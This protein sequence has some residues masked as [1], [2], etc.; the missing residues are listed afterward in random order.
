LLENSNLRIGSANAG[1]FLWHGAGAL[2]GNLSPSQSLTLEGLCNQNAV[3]TAAASFTNAGTV[4]LTS[5]GCGNLAELNAGTNTITNSG[6]IET[7]PGSAGTRNLVG[8]L[9]NS[10]HL[11][12]GQAL[13][14]NGSL[15]N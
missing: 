3:A 9:M 8:N 15:T 5:T 2:T 14:L 4:T 7:T 13:T 11:T 6:T 1:H 12:V 10:G